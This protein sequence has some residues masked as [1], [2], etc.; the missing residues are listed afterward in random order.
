MG[1]DLAIDGDE[2]LVLCLGAHVS[3]VSAVCR[4]GEAA[5]LE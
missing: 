2:P 1:R 3:K 5:V 4:P